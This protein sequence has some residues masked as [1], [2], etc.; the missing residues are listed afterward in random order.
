MNDE[1]YGFTY[2]CIHLID[3]FQ[4]AAVENVHLICQWDFTRIVITKIHDNKSK[5]MYSLIIE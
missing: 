4:D 1:N 2:A 3:C 5:H